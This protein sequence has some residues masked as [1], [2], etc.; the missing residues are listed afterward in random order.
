MTK[1]DTST[2][3]AKPAV[4]GAD[5]PF[6]IL[7]AKLSE[8]ELVADFVRSSA[9]WYRPIVDEKDMGQ[10]AVGPQWAK[11]NYELRDFYIGRIGD[12]PI[13][14]ISIQ[15]FGD[16]AYLGYI[17]LDVAYVGLG[18]GGRLMRFAQ[19]VAKKTGARGLCLIAHPKATWARK[20]YLKFGF[21]ITETSR[22]R[23]LAWKDG[24]LRPYYEE[25]FELYQLP[26]TGAP[27]RHQLPRTNASK[28]ESLSL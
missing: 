3:C 24:A 26:L 12:K 27:S 21:E 8:M 19:D 1:I 16:W 14:T 22:E 4:N 20:A 10:H 17:Y 25:G 15:R 28:P 18:Y 13:G 7:P 11:K 2:P 5:A 9:E 6:R 23:V